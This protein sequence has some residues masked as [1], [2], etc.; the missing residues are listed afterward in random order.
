MYQIDREIQDIDVIDA[1]YGVIEIVLKGYNEPIRDGFNKK[2]RSEQIGYDVTNYLMENQ[3]IH[4]GQ[5]EAQ[6]RLDLERLEK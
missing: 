2:S 6:H 4:I 3:F 5:N 1:F